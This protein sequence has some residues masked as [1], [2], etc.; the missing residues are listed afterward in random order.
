MCKRRRSEWLAGGVG[1]VEAY[2]PTQTSTAGAF[3]NG[4]PGGL[5]GAI[6]SKADWPFPTCARLPTNSG[7]QGPRKSPSTWI[8]AQKPATGRHLVT[9]SR[10]GQHRR[11]CLRCRLRCNNKQPKFN[12]PQQR[13]GGGC[14]TLNKS[15]TIAPDRS[16]SKP[17]PPA[18]PRKGS[19]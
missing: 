10:K 11:R 15:A 5:G 8:I 7:T 18:R 19:S 3:G 17:A 14:N 13:L 9:A 1:A 12:M 4:G 16:R 6:L 2:N